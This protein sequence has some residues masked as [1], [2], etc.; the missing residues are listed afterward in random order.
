[1]NIREPMTMLTDYAL[2]GYTLYLAF[3]LLRADNALHMPRKL[4]GY[5]FVATAIAALLGG[6]SH[7]FVHYLSVTADAIIWKSTLYCI[8]AAS[9][10]MLLGIIVATFDSWLRTIL[11]FFTLAKFAVF[12]FWM[13]G[14]SDFK[15]VIY[16]YVPSMVAI[17]LIQVWL[18][19]RSGA[20]SAKWLIY[21]ILV[22]F[23]AAGVQ[24]SGFDLHQHFNHNDLYHVVQVAA[25]YLLYRGA[26]LLKAKGT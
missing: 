19:I 16:D 12:G 21:G 18:L 1:M 6:T 11:S 10:F 24:Q 23:A 14:H 3:R 5:G 20:A 15:Y 13:M 26:V 17:L 9:C 8:G 25:M 22:S 7:G 2:A 4:W